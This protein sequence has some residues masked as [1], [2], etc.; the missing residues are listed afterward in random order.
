MPPPTNIS[1]FRSF[2][3]MANYLSRFIP[4][5]FMLI[6]HLLELTKK[7]IP[8][9]WTHK[10]QT[11]FDDLKTELISPKVMFYYDPSLNSLV[12]TD[13]NPTL[14]QQSSSNSYHI[15]LYSSIPTEHN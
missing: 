5:Y 4:N 7:N 14:I 9:L 12:I 8:W 11:I 2:L 1:E 13:T 3:G 10:D 6:Y 15:I